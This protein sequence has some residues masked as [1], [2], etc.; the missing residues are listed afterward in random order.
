MFKC[1][2]RL[3]DHVEKLGDNS[4]AAART[5]ESR[6]QVVGGGVGHCPAH[7]VVV[8]RGILTRRNHYKSRTQLLLINLVHYSQGSISQHNFHL[9]NMFSSI[10]ILKYLQEVRKYSETWLKIGT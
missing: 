5:T 8:P 7:G 9:Q 2:L 3:I 4:E 1:F 10:S 6:E